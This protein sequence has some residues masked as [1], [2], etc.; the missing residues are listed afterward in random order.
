MGHHEETELF[1]S[2]PYKREKCILMRERKLL[3]LC[4][5]VPELPAPSCV[6][7]VAYGYEALLVMLIIIS[8][9]WL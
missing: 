9:A 1:W 5:C 8:K 3:I 4:V 7:P 2:I 6:G